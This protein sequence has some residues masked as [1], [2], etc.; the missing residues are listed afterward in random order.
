MAAAPD[1]TRLGA[2]DA[3][4]FG[5][6]CSSIVHASSGVFNKHFWKVDVPRAAVAYPAVWHAGIALAAIHLSVRK[7]SSVSSYGEKHHAASTGA[8]K[9][10]YNNS[11]SA[12]RNNCQYLLAL[13]HFHKSIQHLSAALR[14]QRCSCA[15]QEM[16]ILTNVLF[17]GI[18]GM[19][20]DP[21]QIRSHYKNLFLLL[22]SFRFGGD[23]PS[24]S[25]D[26]V[27]GERKR[28]R[29]IM[30][31]D[32]LRSLVLL[33]EASYPYSWDVGDA[34]VVQIP[35]YDKFTSVTQ[36]YTE[37][38]LI[39]HAR[40]R[41][42][43]PRPLVT[44]QHAPGGPSVL[45]RDV[46][47]F[48]AKLADLERSIV[49]AGEVL[50]QSSADAIE[51]MRQHMKVLGIRQRGSMRTCREHLIQDEQGLMA[52]LDYLERQLCSPQSPFSS[53]PAASPS[54]EG[55]PPTEG[56][57]PPFVFSP[58][59]GQLLEMLTYLLGNLTIRRRAVDLMRRYPYKEGGSRSEESL[60]C[61]DAMISHELSGPELT[62]ASQ[63][64]GMPIRPTYHNGGL[65]DRQFDGT[66]ECE[67]IYGLFICREHKVGDFRLN[68]TSKTPCHEV[69]N[70]YE[71]RC[72]LSYTR[73]Y[74]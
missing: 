72:G 33:L 44:G 5:V 42:R 56:N 53:S 74:F 67:C 10:M 61:L 66:R 41:V 11:S 2:D 9:P 37:F 69:A 25:Q 46:V 39:L 13:A 45:L 36:A 30:D 28:R 38:L 22:Q 21:H 31:H 7:S 71:M 58:S 60:A 35:S 54:T 19:L 73:Y 15:D 32:E 17:I 68:V 18:T 1:G 63:L 50:D 27:Y 59:F 43:R 40:L 12:A 62:R 3:D 47:A 29:G 51:Y 55:E 20:E 52:V 70:R 57:P 49:A 16:A 34:W 64:A 48:E 6:F 4:L 8:G 23:D 65:S 24:S 26:D 14:R